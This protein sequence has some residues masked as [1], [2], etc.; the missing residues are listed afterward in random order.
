MKMILIIIG[1]TIGICY[2]WSKYQYITCYQDA[3]M[4]YMAKFEE[5][6]KMSFSELL[7]RIGKAHD[8]KEK[9]VKGH[10]FLVGWRVDEPGALGAFVSDKTPRKPT[11]KPLSEI[12]EVE[13]NGYVDFIY[14]IP[15]TR[16]VHCGWSFNFFKKKNGDIR[17]VFPK[18]DLTSG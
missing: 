11:S 14:P 10:H 12:D 16:L 2:L 6:K 5:L 3:K 4:I 9:V 15:F 13:V 18:H 17:V 8:E 1:V 7:S